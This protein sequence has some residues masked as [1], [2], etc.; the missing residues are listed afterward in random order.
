MFYMHQERE[1][2]KWRND[3]CANCYESVFSFFSSWLPFIEDVVGNAMSEMLI[4][5]S[6]YLKTFMK[7]PIKYFASNL[8]SNR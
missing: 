1:S 2:I 4:Y 3:Y 6:V 8:I 5:T 7:S